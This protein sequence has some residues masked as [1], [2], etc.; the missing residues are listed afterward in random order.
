MKNVA[1]FKLHTSIFLKLACVADCAKLL[2][3]LAQISLA[4]WIQ[5]WEAVCFILDTMARVT[6]GLIP[7]GALSD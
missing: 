2:T 4:S 3:N 1:T 6:T 5:A 7:L